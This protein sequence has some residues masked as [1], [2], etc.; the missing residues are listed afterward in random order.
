MRFLHHRLCPVAAA[1][2][3]W[4]ATTCTP[5]AAEMTRRVPEDFPTIHEAIEASENGD[6]ILVG[7]GTYTES[8]LLSETKGDGLIIRSTEGSAHTTIAFADST[9]GNPNESVVTFQRCTNSTQFVGFR[10]DGRGVARRGILTN[11]DS[12]PVLVD[13]FVDGCEYG[14]AAHRGSRPY[15]RDITAQNSVTADLFISGGSADVRN[16]LFTKAEKFGVYI[17]SASEEVRLRDV[18]I[19]DNGQVGLQA[20]ESALSFEDGEVA[21]NGDTGIILNDTSPT[22]R[23]LTISGHSNIGIVM[24]ICSGTLENCTIS[25]NQYGAVSSIEGSPRIFNCTFKDN[26]AY[27][28]GIEGDAQPLI[29]GSLEHANAFL[30]HPDFRLQHTSSA[31]VIANYNYWDLPC[32]P[33]K[34]FDISGAGKLKRKPWVSGNLLRVFDDCR[35]ARKYN[36]WWKNGKLDDEGNHIKHKTLVD[37]PVSTGTPAA[38]GTLAESP[39]RAAGQ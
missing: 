31:D 37:E 22:L 19:V 21:R 1:V 30:G 36:R 5:A 12:K 2:V 4:A 17:G 18:R 8:I 15:L 24:E 39:A 7:P 23:N 9:E 27:H 13:I 11:S 38:G 35:L 25:D 34:F 10:I 6:T 14:I 16:A 33:K 20:A 28:V 32:V 26:T 29:G 3:A